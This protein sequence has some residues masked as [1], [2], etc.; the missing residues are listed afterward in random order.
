MDFLS[1][2]LITVIIFEITAVVILCY[3]MYHYDD[4]DDDYDDFDFKVE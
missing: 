3:H 4:D 1:A 2:F